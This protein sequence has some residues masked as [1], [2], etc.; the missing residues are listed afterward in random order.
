[1]CPL[2][3]A[4]NDRVRL[5]HETDPLMWMRGHNNLPVSS[6]VERDAGGGYMTSNDHVWFLCYECC[7][8]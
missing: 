1:M 5:A 8:I 7:A 6:P 2:A 4:C 3:T